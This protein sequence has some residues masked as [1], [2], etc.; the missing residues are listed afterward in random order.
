MKSS[1]PEATNS[2]TWNSSTYH[3]A[4]ANTAVGQTR[5]EIVLGVAEDVVEARVQT[6]AF[7][8]SSISCSVGVGISSTSVNSAKSSIG[9]TP[10]TL[11]CQY[12]GYPGIGYRYLQWLEACEST[13]TFYGDNNRPTYMQAGLDAMVMG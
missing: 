11:V 12:R 13:I 8:A 6:I 1:W 5:V 4:N 2:W 7:A 9:L 3:A 10:T